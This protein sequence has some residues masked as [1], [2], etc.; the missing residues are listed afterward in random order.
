MTEPFRDFDVSDLWDD[1]DSSL[2]DYV[3]APVTPDVVL[4]VERE[5]GYKL[6]R[7][8]VEL[9]RRHN[10][11]MLARNAHPTDA[12]TSWA[13]DHIAVNGIFSIGSSKPCS[14]LGPFG[15]KFWQ[16]EWEYPEIGV[17]FADCPSGGHDMLCLDYRGCGPSGEPE[18]VHIDQESDFEITFVADDFESFIRGLVSEEAFD[19]DTED[20]IS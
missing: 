18:V 7:A 14:L 16:A 20:D 1:N 15:S 3:D 13:S 10:G 4:S 9:A 8:Y 11:G 6:P 2:R 12:P 19:M 5:L 17:Y